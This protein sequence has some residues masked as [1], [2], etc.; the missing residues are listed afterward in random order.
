MIGFSIST[1]TNDGAQGGR[2]RARPSV[3]DVPDERRGRQNRTRGEL[4]GGDGVEELKP[5]QP[6]QVP[7]QPA[8]QEGDEDVPAP[9]QHRPDLQEEQKQLSEREAR[10]RARRRRSGD[11]AGRV[12]RGLQEE[13]RQVPIGGSRVRSPGR[14]EPEHAEHATGQ[15]RR[16]LTDAE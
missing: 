13:D 8:L 11:D 6:S 14:A 9:V 1:K 10:R 15:Q 5:S 12:A 16:N 7:D 2:T 4:T 3:H